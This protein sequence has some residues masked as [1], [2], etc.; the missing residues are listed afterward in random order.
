M[1]SKSIRSRQA[2]EWSDVRKNVEY[3]GCY[4]DFGYHHPEYQDPKYYHVPKAIGK[5][6]RGS[7]LR[8]AQDAMPTGTID[9]RLPPPRKYTA[10]LDGPARII[11][12]IEQKLTRLPASESLD[13]ALRRCY[14]LARGQ[15]KKYFALQNGGRLCM[16]TNSPDFMQWGKLPN[17]ECKACQHRCPKGK[18]PCGERCIESDKHCKHH[19]HKTC[20]HDATD[21]GEKGGGYFTNSVFKIKD[22]EF[23]HETVE[24]APDVSDEYS[25]FRYAKPEIKD[26]MACPNVP[27]NFFDLSPA[28]LFMQQYFTIENPI[29]GVIVYASAGAGKTC[30]A[31]NVIG[32]FMGKWEIFWVTR[33]S[34]R[35]TP[36]KNLYRDICQI[37][38]REIIDDPKPITK[39]TGE[40]V[41]TTRD[42]KIAYI[43]SPAAPAVL[44][45]YGIE[46]EKQRIISYDGFVKMIVGQG[47][48]C[49]K[50]RNQQLER[51]PNGDMGYQTLFVFDEAHNLISSGL[52]AE[53]RQALDAEFDSVEIAGKRF[54]RRSDVYGDKVKDSDAPI[55]GRDLIPAMFWQ[56]YKAS[57]K[58][59]AK[60]LIL[61]G[62]PMSTSPTDLF[63]LLNLTLEKHRLSLDL[64]DYYDPTTMKLRDE[65]VVRFAQAAHGRI[66]YLD[67]TQNPTT[68][69]RKIFFER[70]DSALHGFHQKAIDD[71][72]EKE[73]AK[74]EKAGVP[75][76][77]TRMV[78]IYQNL[79]LVAKTK[80]SFFDDETLRQ[81][82]REMK[83]LENWNPEEERK[84]Q[85]ELYLRDVEHA[86]KLFKLD[87][88]D[89][90]RK[91]YEK[92]VEQYRT[93]ANKNAAAIRRPDEPD[94]EIR[95]VIDAN[96]DLIP[97]TEWLAKAQSQMPADQKVPKDVQKRYATLLKRKDDWEA[98]V[99][100]GK[101]PRRPQIGELL[102][103]DGTVKS[104]TEFYFDLWAAKH[105]RRRDEKEYER[106]V[107]K[108]KAFR[109]SL[110]DYEQSS[111]SSRKS[112]RETLPS[113]PSGVDE[114]MDDFGQ[115]LSMEQ[116]F[117]QRIA[118]KRAK[119]EKKKYS[120]E[121]TKYLKFL[122]RDPASGLMRV[123][124]MEEFVQVRDP[125][126]TLEG[127]ET[128]KGVSLLMWHKTFD[129][130][131]YRQLMPYYAPK[132]HDCIQN[133]ISLEEQALATY[134]HGL[135]H[136]VFT[137]TT[138]GKG[139]VESVDSRVVASAFHAFSDLFRVCLVYKED[140]DGRFV[141]HHDIP[142]NGPD[143][144][145]WGVAM[146]SSKSMPNVYLGEHGGNQTVEYNAKIVGATQAAWNDSRNRYGDR[147]KVCI[148]D[149]AYTEGV[150]VFD[151]SV[152]HFLNEGL[153]KSQLEQAGSRPVRF[154]Q[155]KSIPFF[156]G[157]GGFVEM[158]FYAQKDVNE[159]MLAHVPY[160]EQLNLNMM[161]V[162]KDLAAQFSIDYWLNLNVNDFR[163][164]YKGQLSGTYDKWNRAYL[165]TKELEVSDKNGAM[166]KSE[167]EINYQFIVDPD[168][169]MTPIKKGSAVV[170]PSGIPAFVT[171]WS[172]R[173]FK[174]QYQHDG[175][176]ALFKESDLRLAP[177]Q[178]VDFQIPYGIDLAQKVMN[179]GNYNVMHPSELT[180]DMVQDINLPQNALSVVSSA[181]RNNVLFVLLGMVAMLRMIVK[182]GGAGIPIRIVMPTPDEGDS[183]PAM[184]NFSVRWAFSPSGERVAKYHYIPFRDFLAQKEGIAIMFL[185]LQSTPDAPPENDHVN[186]L[187]Y[188]PAWGVVERYDPLGY[189]SHAY[190]SVELDARLYDL[191]Q[192]FNPE[193]LYMSSAETS[194]LFGLQRL[195]MREKA[196]HPMDPSSYNTVFALFYMHTRILHA[197][198][199]LKEYPKEKRNVFP[200]QFQRGLIQALKDRKDTTLT[201]YIRNYSALAVESKAFVSSW[202]QYDENLPF[203]ANTARLVQILQKMASKKHAMDDT[204]LTSKRI[205]PKPVA[206]KQETF[207]G[208]IKSLV[209]FLG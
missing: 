21:T 142:S 73:K 119:K 58:N 114:V 130:D 65:A 149:G 107:E 78:S 18:K 200:I 205:V 99:K 89:S 183:V 121:E 56:S 23:G 55:T 194:P 80:G 191:F 88:R 87:V 164:V 98:K 169:I 137:F 63:W 141:L 147:I 152:A 82:E 33:K 104:E 178:P 93:W 145:R 42:E 189:V 181:F 190:N 11:P 79:S 115:L 109:S 150:E 177:G 188:N 108:F 7:I 131:A 208:R 83:R 180:L 168:S 199:H 144:N 129:G 57:G 97:Q 174:I 91:A 44:K 134:G 5:A 186:L 85:T 127:K 143:D 153:S 22:M 49:V 31:L 100:E 113:R 193:L 64:N 39:S 72:V 41:A 96:G 173:M 160:E 126:P 128:R 92:K 192:K 62:T 159:Q 8:Y 139:A 34:L 170:D 146:L 167:R 166:Q 179:I 12:S 53:E 106:L 116:W 10:Y 59:S 171:D 132:I 138:G 61:T 13:R 6:S 35:E 118:P 50:L 69:A 30:E 28:Q 161:D 140:D 123:R 19:Q 209:N 67:I 95:D 148:L 46:I 37:R 77:W 158:Y 110:V 54:S 207:F 38:L 48:E 102:K 74:A 1:S 201:E 182:A 103:A 195:Q 81:Y 2:K 71:A 52:P 187:V 17:G 76:D 47:S 203:W 154:C 156:K 112:L 122:I 185:T 105:I 16:A 14:D 120:K 111:K 45:R 90:D 184:S 26:E 196:R 124:S 43:R 27:N 206:Q 133:I 151:D 202:N 172:N 155:S 66:S 75:V 125:A 25:K 135:K 32:N 86:K 175:S 204:A 84:Y 36:L 117:E 165:V 51:S 4:G 70:M 3:E 101:K 176:E 29:K 20:E 15:N 40:V 198:Q 24:E 60:C 163:P 157:V 94:E 197:A 162:F 136:M 68:F 9:P